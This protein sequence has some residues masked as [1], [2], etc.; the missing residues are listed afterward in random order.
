MLRNAHVISEDDSIPPSGTWLHKY[1]LPRPT[2]SI[3]SSDAW[4]NA[5]AI[6]PRNHLGTDDCYRSSPSRLP[7]RHHPVSVPILLQPILP[8]PLQPR[9]A[10][11]CH[12]RPHIPVSCGCDP[13]SIFAQR[14]VFV[15]VVREA[16]IFSK[17]MSL[18]WRLCVRGRWKLIF[19]KDRIQ[20]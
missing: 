14:Q 19:K 1:C 7:T 5:R 6:R 4:R 16:L 13:G 17:Y 18:T 20:P 12:R 11:A 8:P 15:C 2:T 9:I 10:L 3:F